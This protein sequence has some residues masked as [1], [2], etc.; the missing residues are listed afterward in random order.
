MLRPTAISVTVQKDYTLK[1]IF[2]NGETK[3]FDVKPYIKGSWYSRLKDF[4]YFS[5]AKAD[6]FTVIWPEGQDI[7]PDE[8]YY[9]SVPIQYSFNQYSKKYRHLPY[10]QKKGL[11]TMDNFSK[12]IYEAGINDGRAEGKAEYIKNLTSI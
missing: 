6:G 5:L 4:S 8:L 11:A 7:C 12:Q 10:H 3:I 9:N 2:N 1:V